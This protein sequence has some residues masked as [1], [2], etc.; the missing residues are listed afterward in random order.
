MRVR[1]LL[2]P[3]ALGAALTVWPATALFAGMSPA[4]QARRQATVVH[5]GP[6]V[7]TVGEL[8]DRLAVVPRF[9]LK[10]FGETADAI[11]RK[12]FDQVVLP[13]ALYALAASK[14]HLGDQLPTSNK[15]V[16]TQANAST[17][18]LLQGLR[19]PMTIGMPEVQHYY[20]ANRAKYDTPERLYLFRILCATREEAVMVLEIAQKEPT[21]EAFTKLANEHS[22]DKATGM[23]AGNLGYLTPDGASSEAGL[24]VDPAIVKAASGVKDGQFVREPVPEKIGGLSTGFAV[25][26]RRGEV[27]ANHRSVEDAASQIREAIWKEEADKLAKTHL[28]ELRAAHL[29]E[30]NESLLNGIDI[31]ANEGDVVTRRRPGEVAPLTQTGRNAPHATN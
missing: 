14:L 17:K 30:L 8:E 6:T 19:P 31:T 3:L 16:R 18:T 28:E 20:E 12:F 26:W 11:R 4:D 2:I 29:V 23:R 5:V 1:L 13:E 15:L 9:Q 10:A 27:P 21:L 22:I 24:K 25:V 7:I